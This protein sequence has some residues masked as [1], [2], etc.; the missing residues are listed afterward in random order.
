MPPNPTPSGAASDELAALEQV[1]VD[2]LFELQPSYASFLG[3]HQY[4]GR[5][6]D[7]SKE[8]TDAWIVTART[9][10]RR[11]EAIAPDT[12]PPER[13]GDRTLLQLLLEGPIFDLAESRDY[14]RNPMA[15]AGLVSLN[16]YMIRDY[17]PAEARSASMVRIVEAVP[18]ALADGL[19]RL[20]A[21]LPR[22]FLTLADAM[23]SGLPAHLAE[24]DEFVRRHAPALAERSG[25][26][27]AAAEAAVAAFRATLTERFLP[28]A[29]EAYAL[30]PEKFQRLLWVREGLR[31]TTEELLRAGQA[32][33]A[34]NQAR[35]QEIVA[36]LHPP[37]SVP[38]VFEEMFADH[39][40][41][42]QLIPTAQA[43][44]EET[45]RFVLEHR[46]VTVPSPDRCR[47]EETPSYGRALFTASMNP[48]GAFEAKG[49]EGVYYVTPVDTAWTPKQAEEWL[50][51][52]NNALLKNVTVHEAYPG[53]Y[54][55]F[56]HHRRASGSLVRKV[57][58]SGAFTEGWAH[59]TEQ[60]AVEAGLD[61]RAVR[62]EVAQLHDALLRDVR[63]IASIGL[64]TQGKDVAWATRLF[65]TD[66]HFERLPS[67]REAIRGTFNPEYF[68][69][70]LG[71][72][73]ILD[74]RS[75]YLDPRFGGSLLAFHD[76]LLSFGSPPVG[77]IDELLAG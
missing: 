40:S 14:D 26:A 36:T 25:T 72:L 43:F 11:L 61:G 12:L 17:A 32:D 58:M 49:D 54:V 57:F 56:L 27:R 74:A 19:R 42:A 34:R 60:L 4:D 1:I 10:L 20:D 7:L 38:E 2:H 53:H 51:S 77:M 5:L 69:Y 28:R 18:K 41:A 52:F 65:E 64:H 35:L 9:H 55:Q 33:L 62:T 75:K 47:V 24:V 21:K 44:V 22:P 68:C 46:L 48:P 45:R 23:A 6:P 73:A 13:R 15:Y 37:R 39:V 67:E 71:K 3:L 31:T 30:G 63:L 8:F 76:R 16:A 59:Y 70:T 50:R 29:N 66:A